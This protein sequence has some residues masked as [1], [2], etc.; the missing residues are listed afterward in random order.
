MVRVMAAPIIPGSL[1]FSKT[2]LA[3]RD[4][5]PVRCPRVR[6][7]SGKGPPLPAGGGRHDREV[8]GRPG[9]DPREAAGGMDDAVSIGVLASSADGNANRPQ[10]DR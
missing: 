4:A 9:P 7:L 2:S 8:G 3:L 5:R 1:S 10:T 6:Q